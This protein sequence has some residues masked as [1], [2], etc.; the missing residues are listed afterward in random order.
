MSA[1]ELINALCLMV[2][3][4]LVLGSND[5]ALSAI[6]VALFA[7]LALRQASLARQAHLASD[8]GNP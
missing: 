1:R 8:Q 3:L 2:A 7:L 4:A 5:L 6:A